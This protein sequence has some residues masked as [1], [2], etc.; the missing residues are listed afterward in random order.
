MNTK[1]SENHRM[2]TWIESD[3]AYINTEINLEDYVGFVYV[4]KELDTGKLYYGIKKF[5]KIVKL[6]P[7][8]GKK[9]KRHK[10]KETDWRTYK[11]SSPIMQEKL[12]ENPCNYS[13]ELV[14]LCKS[15]TEM[16]AI[17]A[18]LQLKHYIE[19]DWDKLYNEVI[20]LRMRIR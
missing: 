6:K 12:E 2:T 13:C 5:W 15:V 3:M 7:L 19:G 9:N 18:Y 16:K 14:E 17:E 4:I 10:V 1:D 20:N 8:K 11:T